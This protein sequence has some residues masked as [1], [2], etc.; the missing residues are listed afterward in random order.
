MNNFRQ[1]SQRRSYREGITREKT[2]VSEPA[3]QLGVECRNW[4]VSQDGRLEGPETGV[5]EA[6]VAVAEGGI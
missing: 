5:V 3:V 1:R 6:D 4:R 2:L